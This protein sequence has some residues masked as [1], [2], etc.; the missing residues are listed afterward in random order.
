[1]KNEIEA[2]E[3][4]A[5]QYQPRREKIIE[6]LN[7][8]EKMGQTDMNMTTEYIASELT[9][10]E[11]ECKHPHAYRNSGHE[12]YICDDCD[13]SFKTYQ[14]LCVNRIT[15]QPQPEQSEGE[16]E[17]GGMFID[18]TGFHKQQNKIDMK[19]LSVYESNIPLGGDKCWYCGELLFPSTRTVDHFWPKCMRG[20]LKVVCCSNC[21]KMKGRL[22]PLGFINLLESLK[23]KY[24][25]YQPWQKKFDRMIRA[26]Q[27]LW[28]RVK[29]SV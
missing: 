21:N 8:L 9:E 19:V 29:W 18:E 22:T 1:M 27:T 23:E 25:L 13:K 2:M 6:K 16:E 26:T 28:E 10:G 3:E 12:D 11:E 5:S 20:R 14:D 7:Y 24:P 17:N 15:E 4:Y